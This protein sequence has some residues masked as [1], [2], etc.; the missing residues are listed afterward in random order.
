MWGVVYGAIVKNDKKAQ[1][2]NT[3]RSASSENWGM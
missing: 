3:L 1:G 2:R